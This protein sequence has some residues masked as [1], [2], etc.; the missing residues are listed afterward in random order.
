MAIRNKIIIQ[1][2]LK[3]L[4]KTVMELFE[5][6]YLSHKD[7][8]ISYDSVLKTLEQGI[9]KEYL[10]KISI[11]G[12]KDTEVVNR[13]VF[14][15]DWEKHQ[16]LCDS[17]GKQYEFSGGSGIAEQISKALPVLTLFI[18]NSIRSE[19]V[20]KFKTY[21]NYK[22]GVDHDIADK[23]LGLKNLN[24]EDSDEIRKFEKHSFDV[25]I[26][27]EELAELNIQFQTKTEAKFE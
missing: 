26:C 16:I 27:P 17:S 11:L 14:L 1:S 6:S 25:E 13:L 12:M 8:F 21:Y 4:R 3:V 5:G 23:E 19:R 18:R 24:D 10:K 22:N 20:N 15:I 9:E 7:K 2:R